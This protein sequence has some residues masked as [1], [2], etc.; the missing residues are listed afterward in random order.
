MLSVLHG[1]LHSSLLRITGVEG[2]FNLLVFVLSS[3]R[4]C[5]DSSLQ[6]AAFMMW[7]CSKPF[8]GLL[9]NYLAL[10]FLLATSDFSYC[11]FCAFLTGWWCFSPC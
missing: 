9:C 5:G 6:L 7:H 4:T 10:P 8:L 11:T 2:F 1:T 3:L